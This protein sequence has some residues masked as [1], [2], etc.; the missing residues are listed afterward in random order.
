MIPYQNFVIPLIFLLNV[1]LKTLLEQLDIKMCSFYCDTN[2]DPAALQNLK[3]SP[4][5][6]C[7]FRSDSERA[8]CQSENDITHHNWM[9]LTY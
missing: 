7:Q 1:G 6:I 2:C 4:D 5:I 9:F 8:Y 3:K